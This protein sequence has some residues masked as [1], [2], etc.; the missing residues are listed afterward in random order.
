[1]DCLCTPVD[2]TNEEQRNDEASHKKDHVKKE[3]FMRIDATRQA[4]ASKLAL[5]KSKVKA[6]G[7]G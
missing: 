3:A 6:C 5:S 1:M 2:E 4:K 7:A